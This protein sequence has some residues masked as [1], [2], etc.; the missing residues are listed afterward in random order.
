MWKFNNM[1]ISKTRE[2]AARPVVTASFPDMAVLEYEPFAGLK[3]QEVFCVYS[4]GSAIIDLTITNAGAVPMAL[5]LYPVLHLPERLL[6]GGRG[7]I[8]RCNGYV[9]THHESAVRLHSNLYKRP[10]LSHRTSGI[11][12]RPGRRPTATGRTR[13]FAGG[14]LFRGQAV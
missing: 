7:M 4:S 11:S 5:M 2:F 8:R 13:L 1:V 10:G 3:V 6:A 12:F 14:F 9:S